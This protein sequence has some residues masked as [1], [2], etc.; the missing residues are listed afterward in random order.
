MMAMTILVL[1]L[2]VTLVKC[3]LYQ[4]IPTQQAAEVILAYKALEEALVKE[5]D[6]NLV[7]TKTE[8]NEPESLKSEE[9]LSTLK[10]LTVSFTSLFEKINKLDSQ[11]PQKGMGRRRHMQR[12]RLLRIL[13][14]G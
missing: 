12:H 1:I 14:F 9:S 13:R 11:L 8:A 3:G 2:H 10:E 4:R 5:F 6:K 7:E